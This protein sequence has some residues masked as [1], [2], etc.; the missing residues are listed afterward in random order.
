MT[1]MTIEDLTGLLRANAKGSHPSVAAVE[2]LIRSDVWLHRQGF[3]AACVKTD[4]PST[5]YPYRPPSAYLDWN[6]VGAALTAYDA[7][8]GPEWLGVC[9]SGERVLI[10]IAHDIAVGP[11]SNVGS[12]DRGNVALVLAAVSHAAGS[13]ENEHA[14]H[15]YVP[16]ADGVVQRVPATQENS[17]PL[18]PWPPT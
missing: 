6:A 11:M 3:R 14:D 12:L 18:F 4:G 8:E 15:V 5:D 17:G 13:H 16:N 10:Q 7:G 2:L 9:S 1:T